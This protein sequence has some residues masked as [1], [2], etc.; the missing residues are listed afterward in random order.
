MSVDQTRRT[1][2]L[3]LA[4]LTLALAVFLGAC[5]FLTYLLVRWLVS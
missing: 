5:A 3:F 2:G 1:S 4:G